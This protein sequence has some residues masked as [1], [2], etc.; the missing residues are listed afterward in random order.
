MAR[1][2]GTKEKFEGRANITVNV[3]NVNDNAPSFE[4]LAY[5]FLVQ[6]NVST[7][8]VVGRVKV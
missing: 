7:E 6:E 3:V 4:R 1:E 5:I 8:K 2:I